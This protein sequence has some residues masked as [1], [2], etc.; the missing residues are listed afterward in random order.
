MAAMP[1]LKALDTVAGLER[2][3]VTTF[4][5]VSGSGLA[6]HPGGYVTTFVSR[7]FRDRFCDPLGT[8]N[9]SDSLARRARGSSDLDDS[10]PGLALTT[11]PHPF[12]GGPSAFIAA[13]GG[14]GLGHA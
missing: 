9:N 2:I 6:P 11:A 10:S 14:L 13:I 1:V 4:Q 5:A 3:V 8:G 12:Q 7:V